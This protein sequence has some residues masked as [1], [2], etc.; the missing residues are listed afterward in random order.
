MLKLATNARK[1]KITA[2]G[3][4]VDLG[5]ELGSQH[6]CDARNNDAELLAILATGMDLHPAVGVVP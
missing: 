5:S 2:V 4:V 6:N 3:Q 1:L